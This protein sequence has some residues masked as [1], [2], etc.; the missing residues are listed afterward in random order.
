MCGI[1]AIYQAL[2]STML[3]TSALEKQNYDSMK[4]IMGAELG[5]S[6]SKGKKDKVILKLFHRCMYFLSTWSVLI[7]EFKGFCE[8]KQTNGRRKRD[9]KEEAVEIDETRIKRE[10]SLLS[11][12]EI[13]KRSYK[14]KLG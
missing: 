1:A 13:M 10:T 14:T 12:D 5:L 2:E 11:E 7:I 4:E 9:T 3:T 6:K 8:A